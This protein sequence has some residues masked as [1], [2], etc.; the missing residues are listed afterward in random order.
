MSAK[1]S[2]AILLLAMAHFFCMKTPCLIKSI[3]NMLLQEIGTTDSINAV[4][5]GLIFNVSYFIWKSLK[6]EAPRMNFCISGCFISAEWETHFL[7]QR[8]WIKMQIFINWA[9]L[10]SHC[11]N[12]WAPFPGLANW[13]LPPWFP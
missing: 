10:W 1:V 9:T 3:K 12:L 8:N 13:T 11:S 6:Q 7:H 2:L 5:L 4:N